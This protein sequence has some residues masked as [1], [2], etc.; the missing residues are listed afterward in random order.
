MRIS[1]DAG[2]AG[3]LW[4]AAVL[5]GAGCSPVA[6]PER[7]GSPGLPGVELARFVGEV[8][9][10]TG[11]FSIQALESA[12]AVPG[13]GRLEIPTGAGSVT[14]A[15]AGPAWNRAKSPTHACSDADVTGAN[16]VLTQKYASPTFLGAVYAQIDAVSATGVQACNN[17]AKP[18]G[19]SDTWGLW[20]YG[21]LNW[22]TPTAAAASSTA[23]WNWVTASASR[24]TF[25][26]SI[27]GVLGDLYPPAPG[28]LDSA[29]IGTTCITYDGSHVVYASASTTGLVFVNLDGTYA[30]TSQR[31]PARANSLAADATN[32]RIWFTTDPLV[33][34]AYAGYLSTTGADVVSGPTTA[35]ANPT[36]G[37]I[38]VDPDDATRAWFFEWVPG[39]TANLSGSY[40]FSVT[41]G[42]TPG[43]AFFG[44]GTGAAS[45]LA[46]LG[47]GA[48]KRL[49][50]TYRGLDIIEQ[51][52][53]AGV[54][55]G[56][57]SSAT[58]DAAGCQGPADV[59]ADTAGGKL[60]FSAA[61]SGAVCTLTATQATPP[62]FTVTRVGSIS[63]PRGLVRTPG[64]GQVWAVSFSDTTTPGEVQRMIPGDP[65]YPVAVPGTSTLESI[66]ASPAVAG[67]PA[68]PEALWITN[69]SGG[70]VRLQP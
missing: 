6:P 68:Y 69:G 31:L 15:N 10:A 2:R 5:I 49:Y 4:I 34:T 48:A 52:D 19:L 67:P 26:G 22:G 65:S 53:A 41:V 40:I 50:L 28:G 39:G 38:V 62:V 1:T 47:S 61:T 7:P 17:A 3:T 16:V 18:S 23:E 27:R 66:T 55:H 11:S 46:I 63:N 56:T 36:L 20:S 30:S 45:G 8:D 14:I 25:T 37:S 13:P 57:V 51:Y 70:L 29:C 35:A 44:N 64:S 24:F 43:R 12:A 60:W 32:G 33:G 58:L 42:S 21:S 9:G 59:I 54:I